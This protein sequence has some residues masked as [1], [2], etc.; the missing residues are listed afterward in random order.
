MNS[1]CRLLTGDLG[2]GVNKVR[3]IVASASH[4]EDQSGHLQ[5][6]TRDNA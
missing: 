3:A 5:S 1:R 2:I 6:G 4:S